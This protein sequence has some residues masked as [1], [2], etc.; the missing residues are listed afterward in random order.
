VGERENVENV[1]DIVRMRRCWQEVPSIKFGGVHNDD[2]SPGSTG[3]IRGTD[4]EPDGQMLWRL[5]IIAR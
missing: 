1:K 3:V 2:A 4:S 5:L